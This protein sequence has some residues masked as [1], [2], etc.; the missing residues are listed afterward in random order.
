MFVSVLASS[1][2]PPTNFMGKEP[3]G[4]WVRATQSNAAA[5]ASS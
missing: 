2:V 5:A 3:S 4:R 1:T